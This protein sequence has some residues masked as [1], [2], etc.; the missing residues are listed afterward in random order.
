MNRKY[1]NQ[2]LVGISGRGVAKESKLLR[3]SH[4]FQILSFIDLEAQKME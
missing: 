4:S 2:N 3:M 1:D